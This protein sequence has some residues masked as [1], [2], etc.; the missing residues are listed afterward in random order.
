MLRLLD[1]EPLQLAK[2]LTLI[3]SE[4]YL[5]ITPAECLAH[6]KD[7]AEA[8][9][10]DN[11]KTIISTANKVIHHSHDYCACYAKLLVAPDCG[12]G[13]RVDS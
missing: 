4:L 2:Q 6:G 12:M 8:G 9:R 13:C 1:I 11:I 3:E 10:V 7:S 5:K